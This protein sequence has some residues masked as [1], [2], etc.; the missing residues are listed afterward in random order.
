MR[1]GSHALEVCVAELRGIFQT[2]TQ[3]PVHANVRQPDQGVRLKRGKRSRDC[4]AE[5]QNR[6]S[7]SVHQVIG[8]R[9]FG[10]AT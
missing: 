4:H 1:V 8:G 6:H 9:A 10:F 2:K 7:R 5:Q 3:H